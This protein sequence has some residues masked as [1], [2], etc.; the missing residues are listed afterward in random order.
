MSTR[1]RQ[2][3]TK[4]IS[5]VLAGCL[6]LQPCFTGVSSASIPSNASKPQLFVPESIAAMEAQ[7][8]AGPQS[9]KIHLIKDAHTNASCQLHTAKLLE[10]ISA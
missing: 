4:G 7:F 2:I 5:F 8:D 3:S 1:I 6:L 9:K 10:A